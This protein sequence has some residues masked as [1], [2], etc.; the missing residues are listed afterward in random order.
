MNFATKDSS[1]KLRILYKLSN[2][3]CIITCYVTVNFLIKVF[4]SLT[5]KY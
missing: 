3:N 5:F 4:S 1:R 2:I